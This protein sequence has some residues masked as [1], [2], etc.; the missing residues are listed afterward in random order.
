M[1]EGVSSITGRVVSGIDTVVVVNVC[2][3]EVDVVVISVVETELI[4]AI[5]DKEFVLAIPVCPP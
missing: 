4:V 2:S 1:Y 5:C 3:D